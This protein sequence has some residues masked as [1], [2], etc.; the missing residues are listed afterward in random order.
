MTTGASPVARVQTM[1]NAA[2]DAVRDAVSPSSARSGASPSR[3]TTRDSIES[4]AMRQKAHNTHMSF[5]RP[6]WFVMIFGWFL[7]F[8]AGI[9]NTVAY[10]SWGHYA[11]HV[12]GGTTAIGMRLEG[13]HQGR[14]EF[15]T[16]GSAIA[17]LLSFLGGAFTCGLLIDKTHVH[18]GGKAFYGIALVGNAALLAFAVG[19]SDQ[20]SLAATCLAT[21]ACGLQN[22]MCTSHFGAVIRTTHVTGTVTDI[23]STSGR[24]AMIVCRKRCAM[25]RLNVLERAEIAVDARKLLVL[26]PMWCSFL[27][28]TILGA[29]LETVMGVLALLVP[30]GFT[31]FIGLAYLVFRQKMKMYMKSMEQARLSGDVEKMHTTLERAAAV[32]KSLRMRSQDIEHKADEEDADEESL[33]IDLE[34]ELGHMLETMHDVEENIER[35]RTHSEIRLDV[36]SNSALGGS[37]T[38]R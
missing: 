5:Q 30:A 14:L 1:A 26:L 20:D 33:V 19:V 23:G 32:L 9:V 24:I 18:F 17:A 21:A 31:F 11:S 3:R 8:C 28:G 15:D 2:V 38:T 25:R 12:T 16:L 36:K 10:R 34:E 27:A 22:A 6:S 13:Y 29:Y 37:E 7:A 35:I 4:S